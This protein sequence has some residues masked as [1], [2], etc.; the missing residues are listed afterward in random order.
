M[1]WF[2]PSPP[3]HAME[4]QVPNV[5]FIGEQDGPPERLLKDRLTSSNETRAYIRHI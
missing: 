2:K 5:E 4:I 3:K 1:A